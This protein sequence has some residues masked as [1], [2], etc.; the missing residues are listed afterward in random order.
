MTAKEEVLRDD[1]KATCTY[2]RYRGWSG[3]GYR[4]SYTREDNEE[5][6]T[7]AYPTAKAAWESARQDLS[8]QNAAVRWQ[9]ACRH[10]DAVRDQLNRGDA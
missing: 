1:C 6:M 5:S 8:P 4:V 3:S 10:A 7:G 2:Y 9:R